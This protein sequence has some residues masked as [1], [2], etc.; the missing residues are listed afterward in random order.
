MSCDEEVFEWYFAAISNLPDFRDGVDES[1]M[2][3]S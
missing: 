1:F 2:V 3:E